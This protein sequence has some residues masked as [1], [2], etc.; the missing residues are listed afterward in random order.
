[1]AHSGIYLK[2]NGVWVVAAILTPVIFNSMFLGL[3]YYVSRQYLALK[4]VRDFKPSDILFQ[5]SVNTTWLFY[6]KGGIRK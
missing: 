6:F 1:M 2:A 3:P 5:V 4:F